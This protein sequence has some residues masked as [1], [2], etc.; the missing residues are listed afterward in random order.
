VHYD[1]A[2]S[3]EISHIVKQG[4]ERM[5]GT[6]DTHPHGEDIIYY[7]T[8]YNEAFNQ[9]AEPEDVDV[10]GLLKGAYVY[11]KATGDGVPARI[12]ASGVAVPWALKAQ[13]ILA[14]DYGVAADVWS[15]TSWN[16]L[17]RDAIAAEKWNLNNPGEYSKMPYITSRLMDSSA[18]TVAVSDYMRAVPDQIA[19]WVPGP[20]QSL[21]ADGFGFADTRA[22][23]RR[24]FQ[25]DAES[26]VVSVLQTLAQRGSVPP[27]K[28][29]EAFSRFSIDDPTAV[30][31]VE[32]VGGDA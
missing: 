30:A 26:I 6:S 13:Q 32:Q 31:G 14:D 2:F 1:P 10:E 21:G 7:L 17:A 28:A 16:E 8:V 19:R 15:V 29:R 12:M 20:W 9:P 11:K 25:I 23:A 27:E 24:V 3:F 5:Y 4:I 18:V 22:A